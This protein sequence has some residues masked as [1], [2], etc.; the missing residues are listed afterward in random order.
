MQKTL[1]IIKTGGNVLDEP[2]ALEAFLRDFAAIPGPKIL[3]HGGGKIASTLGA[4]LGLQPQYVQGR[5]ITDDAT[6]ELVTMVYGG[7]INRQLCARLQALGCNALGLTGADGNVLRASKRPAGA[8]DYGW[9]GDTAPGQVNTGA[10]HQWLEQGLTPVLAPL[11]HD[12]QGQLLNTNADT[13]ASVVAQAMASSYAVHLVFCFE[14][15]G[16]LE[17]PEDEQ[18]VISVLTKEQY[19]QM[20]AQKTVRD[21]ILPKLDNAFAAVAGGVQTVIAGSAADILANLDPEAVCG[22]K[23]TL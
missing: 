22:T 10:L 20:Q 23:I 14:K 6:L 12:G 4:R 13:I 8:V 5:R 9:A 16:I 21:G 17:D 15:K 1:N 11:T 19:R 2:A 3:I 7:L 18:S